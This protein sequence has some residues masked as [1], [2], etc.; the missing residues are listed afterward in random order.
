MYGEDSWLDS[1][2][3]DRFELD[4]RE[5]PLN[6][7]DFDDDRECDDDDEGEGEDEVNDDFPLYLEYDDDGQHTWDRNEEY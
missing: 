1:S 2:Y 3:E 5:D 4:Y 7:V 6:F